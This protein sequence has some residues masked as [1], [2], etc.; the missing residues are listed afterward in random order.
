MAAVADK[1][2]KITERIVDAKRHTVGYVINGSEVTRTEAIRLAK[3]GW[4][5]NAR[6]AKGNGGTFII[7]ESTNLYDLPIR[8]GK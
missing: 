8:I 7:G 4:L 1:P 2:L 3:R 5:R 6:V